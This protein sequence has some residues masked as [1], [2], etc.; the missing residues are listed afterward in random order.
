METKDWVAADDEVTSLQLRHTVC[1]I[2]MDEA[3]RLVGKSEYLPGRWY[4]EVV[5]R[6][7]IDP[8]DVEGVSAEQ[9][10]QRFQLDGRLFALCCAASCPS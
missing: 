8:Q 9:V 3:A 2:G 10:Y 1:V 4:S 6:F 5:E 7:S